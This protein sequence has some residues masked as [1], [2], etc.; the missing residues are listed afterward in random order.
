M[1]R[2]CTICQHLK[3]AEIDRRL[4]GGEPVAQLARDHQ[5][6]VSSLR[7]HRVNCV[8]LA[9]AGA[10]KKEA[11]RGSAAMALLPSKE[12]LNGA[13]SDLCSRIDEIVAQATQQGS[14]S[15]ALKGLNSIRYAL[16]SMARLVTRDGEAGAEGVGAVQAR[17]DVDVAQ[18]A[19]RLIQ[20]FDREPV[21][22]AR[23]ALALV[24]MENDQPGP[25]GIDQAPE[26]VPTA[27]PTRH[28]SSA[29]VV[30]TVAAAPMSPAGIAPVSLEAGQSTARAAS[31]QTT[32]H[33]PQAS[34]RIEP[35]LAGRQPSSTLE[36]DEARREPRAAAIGGGVS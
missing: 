26:L 20:Q 18:I 25:A 30:D 8:K 12:T 15:I 5:V 32:A 1:S 27:G 7:R 13:Y 33:A 11:A 9:P 16:D 17:A 14:L 28:E 21:L 34:G 29:S 19:E 22:K 3:R 36:G 31:D 24:A 6:T 23:I 4:A 35:P 2:S 10:I